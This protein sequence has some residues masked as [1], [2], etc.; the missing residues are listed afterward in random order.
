[1]RFLLEEAIDPDGGK[2]FSNVGQPL[3]KNVHYRNEMTIAVL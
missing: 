3:M 1:M 2:M